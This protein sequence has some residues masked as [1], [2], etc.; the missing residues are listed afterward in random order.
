MKHDQRDQVNATEINRW[1]DCPVC[2]DHKIIEVFNNQMISLANIDMT[3]RIGLCSNC[4]FS[5]AFDLP[6]DSTYEK[7]YNELSKYDI[8]GNLSEFD[9]LRFDAIA[10]LCARSFSTHSII[11]DI[12]C[13]DGALLSK[14]QGKGFQKIYGIE[15]A[16]NASTVAKE[17]YN[18]NTI[19]Q[20][21]FND[22]F[23]VGP[24]NVA[25]C[26]LFS[27][28][29]EHLPNLRADLERFLPNL[30]HD[31]KVIIEVPAI[32]LF[33]SDTA[34]P[35][36]EFSIEH[37]NFFSRNS[38]T[39]LMSS[40]G[41]SCI[42]SQYLEYSKFQTGSVTSI[43]EKSSEKSHS[44]FLP[45]THT[46][47]AYIEA[48]GTRMSEVLKRIPDREFILYGAGSHSARLIPQ[49]GVN[50]KFLMKAIVDGNP[51]LIGKTLGQ[52]PIDAPS[53]IETMPTIPIV[54]SSYRSQNAIAKQLHSIYRNPLISLYP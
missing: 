6:S 22:A 9:L 19:S 52:W 37:I 33:S 5:F 10:N 17:K 8:T 53:I 20:G 42:H 7:Y 43:F 21:F 27:A 18:I 15:P 28:V 4:G 29:L 38:L 45:Q 47:S 31:C 39:N 14:L 44:D 35:Y 24:V 25:D 34:E 40:L 1:R 41:W 3:Y 32:E 12:G 2:E 11:V 26:I 36:G 48:C 46:L 54:I 30:K 16:P 13:G 51:N 50:S 23:S 49:L